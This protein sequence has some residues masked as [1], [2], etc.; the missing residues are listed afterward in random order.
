MT[1][2]KY[3]SYKFSGYFFHIWE[4]MQLY[5]PKKRQ[6]LKQSKHTTRKREKNALQQREQ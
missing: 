5:R 4:S 3:L 6:N 1:R 2:I